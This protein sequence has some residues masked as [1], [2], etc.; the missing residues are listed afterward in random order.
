MRHFGLIGR[1]LSHSFSQSLFNDRF[2]GAGL[3]YSLI[4]LEGI[5]EIHSA[6]MHHK[7]EGF[8]V[9]I[10]YKVDIMPYL[11]DLDDTAHSVGAVNTVSVK[12]NGDA[13][14]LAGHNT[15]AP[16]FAETLRPLLQ[17]WH[18]KALILG[19]GG[20]ARA[21]AYALES[22]GIDYLFVSRTPHSALQIDY[23]TA[24]LCAADRTVIVNATPVGMFP[25]CSA[26][27]WPRCE[28]LGPRHLCYDLV[29]NPSPTRFL[30]EAAE[31]G[32]TVTDGLAMLRLQAQKSWHIWG[33]E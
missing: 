4:E 6:V 27:P 29:Y 2:D 30:A 22:L 9:T 12:R 10:P 18:R 7:L 32:A 24:Y 23:E 14:L 26:T 19:T 5:D 28:L 1:Q 25:G 13:M 11:D 8:N 33:L 16:A 21:V 17:P 3:L 15:D 20:A 31:H